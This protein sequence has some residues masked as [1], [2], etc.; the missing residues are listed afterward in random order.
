MPKLKNCGTEQNNLPEIE[1]WNIRIFQFNWYV[2]YHNEWV[3]FL[4]HLKEIRWLW[5]WMNG[6]FLLV[7]FNYISLVYM[8]KQ[9]AEYEWSCSLFNYKEVNWSLIYPTSKGPICVVILIFRMISKF[10]LCTVKKWRENR[11]G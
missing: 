8:R 6:M 10:Y 4:A 2:M 11:P 7:S 9:C 5:D 1:W 3:C